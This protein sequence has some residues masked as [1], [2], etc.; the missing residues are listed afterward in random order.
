MELQLNFCPVARQ[1]ILTPELIALQ[2]EDQQ[3]TFAELHQ[4]VTSLTDQLLELNMKKGDRLVSIGSNRLHLLL[5]Q[6]TCLRNSFIFCPINPKFS[7]SEI[8][9]RLVLLD[10]PFVW[11]ENNSCG[12][13]F[14]FNL[15]SLFKT[16]PEPISINAKAVI[17][18]IFT[19]GSSGKPKAIMHN[20]SNHFYSALGSQ[21]VISLKSG[22][23]NL[24]SLPL[25]HISGYATVM[26]TLLAGATL[27]L[28]DN[29]LTVGHLKKSKIS[30]LSLVSSQLQQLLADKQF[31]ATNLSIK[32][33]LLGGSAFPKK[34]LQ[35]LSERGFTYHLSYGSTEMAS[36]VATSTNSEQLQI[37]PYRQLKIID[38]EICLA[39][40]TRFVGYFTK[41]NKRE[42]IN[43]SN[44][45]ASSD[46]GEL[47][48][49]SLRVIGRK[50]RQFIS[51]GENIQPEEIEQLLLTH[52]AVL[53]AYVLPIDDAKYG[54]RPI[55][56]IKWAKVDQSM[57]LK[58]FIKEK[59]IGFKHP[60]H[61]LPLPESQGIKPNPKQLVDI[62]LKLLF[63]N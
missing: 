26:R 18:I 58:E 3:V 34:A 2:L 40:E 8:E 16:E 56:F 39:G 45:F 46:M 42:L 37:L 14:N 44:Y 20:F 52:P 29:K 35:Q 59:L 17:S 5:L 22:D 28:S 50:D 53:Q 32:H 1:A 30:H 38:K 13:V 19:S 11:Q 23:K 6:L 60:L 25:F 12:L 33:L 24:L 47:K 57:Q 41:N 48:G 31:K 43:K 61:Y 55:A 7:N 49:D 51:G 63:I 36:Q 9:Q 15:N 62:A 27:Q 4:Y 10:S 54:Q 21:H